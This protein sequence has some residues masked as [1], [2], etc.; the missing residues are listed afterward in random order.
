MAE[1]ELKVKISVDGKTGAL[2]YARRIITATTDIR[3]KTPNIYPPMYERVAVQ[4]SENKS[5]I[6]QQ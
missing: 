1:Q 5:F 3:N 2:G 4:A 6:R